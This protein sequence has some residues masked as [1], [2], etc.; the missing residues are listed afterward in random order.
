M[1]RT[2]GRAAKAVHDTSRHLSAVEGVN[3][4]LTQLTSDDEEEDVIN[5]L[6]YLTIAAILIRRAFRTL[7]RKEEP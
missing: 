6:L 7:T 1:K 2:L 5:A 4:S 3:R